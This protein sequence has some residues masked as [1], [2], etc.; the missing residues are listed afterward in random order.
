MGR[1]VAAFVNVGGAPANLGN[2]P[3]ASRIPV[4]LQ[5][6]PMTCFHPERGVIFLMAE[7]GMPIIHLLNV[8]EVAGDYG[9]PFDPIP[10]PQIG[11]GRIYLESRH[12]VKF[13]FL[14]LALI[15]L[16]L[17]WAARQSGKRV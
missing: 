11:E 4:G 6:R 13:V 14:S 15:F 7:L 1:R 9:L 10:L 2:C 3:R 5:L 12:P 16:T 17:L 8:R